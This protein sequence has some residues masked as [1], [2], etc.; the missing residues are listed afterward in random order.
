MNMD[1]MDMNMNT[2]DGNSKSSSSSSSSSSS[3]Y[4][5]GGH[6]MGMFFDTHNSGFYVMFE[7][8]FI[9]SR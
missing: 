6:E 5:G 1:D 4:M 2:D 3:M 8:A 7:T 9:K